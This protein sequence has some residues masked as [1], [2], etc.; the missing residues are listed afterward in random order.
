[1][2]KITRLLFILLASLAIH[3]SAFAMT[4]SPT[5]AWVRDAVFGP[6]KANII[7]DKIRT[8]ET[9]FPIEIDPD[10][11]IA[12]FYDGFFIKG[13]KYA[14]S[15]RCLTGNHYYIS[16]D[17]GFKQQFHSQKF[18]RTPESIIRVAL[19]VGESSF[20][21]I[22]PELAK[23]V[24]LVLI[25]DIQHSFFSHFHTML[26]L[27]KESKSPQDF[28][29]AYKQIY[30][31]TQIWA[32][33][34]EFGE[35]AFFASEKRFREM[36]DAVNS[37][38]VAT[39]MLNMMDPVHTS[40]LGNILGKNTALKL[41]N[42]TNLRDYQ[43]K[44]ALLKSL[45]PLIAQLAEDHSR[46][47]ILHSAK[48]ALFDCTAKS[49]LGIDNY[50]KEDIQ[51]ELA[52]QEQNKLTELLAQENRRKEEEQKRKL[53]ELAME[54]LHSKDLFKDLNEDVKK[55]VLRHL[56][57]EQIPVTIQVQKWIYETQ[58]YSLETSEN[59]IISKYGYLSD[60]EIIGIGDSSHGKHIRDII[61]I[62]IK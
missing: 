30:K 52:E 20:L 48:T 6:S 45:P 23:E 14:S 56:I 24:D 25:V 54:F 57:D 47:P 1:M 55:E 7:Q 8:L 44:R 15:E 32:H 34:E 36:Q 18:T 50:L 11:K 19:L 49:D 59:K 58:T 61:S 9:A 40:K 41:L 4:L 46:L 13:S 27:A 51:E 37:L 29:K 60:I 53:H 26:K 62:S 12:E 28:M 17:V 5:L 3:H 2:K 35:L 10:I 42:T 31:D 21:S 22:A 16:N 33:K 39:I 43:K 38:P